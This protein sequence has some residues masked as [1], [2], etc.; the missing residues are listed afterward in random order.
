MNFE[1]FF[2]K[3]A[4]YGLEFYK[5]YYG[6]YR[7]EVVATN[8]PK[9]RG[10]VQIYCPEV[11][12]TTTLNVWV[13]PAFHASG[14]DRG[15]FWP[16]E[17]GDSV[18]VSFERGDSSKPRV[19][20]GGWHGTDEI[21]SEIRPT[22]D[23]PPKKRGVALRTGHRFFFD[24]TAG[25]E[26]IEL[27]WQAPTSQPVDKATAPRTGTAKSTLLFDKDGSISLSSRDAKSSIKLDATSGSVTI[28][29]PNNNVITMDSSGVKI[30]TQGNVTIDG[31]VSCAINAQMVSLCSGADSPAV[32][33]TDLM[34]WLSSHAH[35]C[36][37]GPTTP[38]LVP[39]T[40]NILSVTTTLK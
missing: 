22:K 1:I 32:R 23:Q 13:D 30:S 10:R 26:T 12:H 9:A 4:Q 31:A 3:L 2:Q 34:T 11:G 14:T 36:A 18:W 5:R 21:P 25:S 16:P 35:G 29:D 27:T 7:A 38:P 17:V 8:D 24:E 39:P 15:W 28:K 20:F 37:V 19:Y 33:G 40:P 6:I